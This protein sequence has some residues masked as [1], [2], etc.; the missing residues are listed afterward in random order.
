MNM[1]NDRHVASVVEYVEFS[2]KPEFSDDEIIAAVNKTESMLDNVEGYVRRYVSKREDK[3]VEVVFWK[4][5]KSAIAGL[6][7]FKGDE[8]SA[9]LFNLI[10][11]GSV[12]IRYSDIIPT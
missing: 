5:N 11:E 4:D 7:Y 12:S 3:W 9:D 10:E 8:R 2:A 1:I 6:E